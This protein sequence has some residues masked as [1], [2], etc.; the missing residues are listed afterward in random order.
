MERIEWDYQ[1]E[2]IPETTKTIDVENSIRAMGICGWR[3]VAVV[4]ERHYFVRPR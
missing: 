3:L 2:V 4:G 1:I